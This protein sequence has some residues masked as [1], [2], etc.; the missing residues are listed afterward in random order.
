MALGL[1]ACSGVILTTVV[2]NWF[3]KKVSI[4]TGIVVSGG[5]FGGLMV[6]LVTWLIDSFTWRTAMLILGSSHQTRVLAPCILG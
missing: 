3:H 6:P 1:S 4:A 5:A 2:G